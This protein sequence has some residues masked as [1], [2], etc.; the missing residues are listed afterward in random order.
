M[1]KSPVTFYLLPSTYLGQLVNDG[2]GTFKGNIPIPPGIAP[3]TEVLRTA[4]NTETP[5]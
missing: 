3:E 5:R 2:S 4:F 1:A